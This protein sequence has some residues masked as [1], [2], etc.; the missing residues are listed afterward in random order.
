M[1]HR[2][3]DLARYA[4][5]LWRGKW[6]ILPFVVLAAGAA[7]AHQQYYAHNM[8]SSSVFLVRTRFAIGGGWH[9]DLAK[10]EILQA[11]L[12]SPEVKKEVVRRLQDHTNPQVA[13]TFAQADP[14]SLDPIVQVFCP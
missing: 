7:I 13:A 9:P 4:Q 14:S 2:E 12:S 3:I 5:I 6:L 8:F 11:F 1:E 10:G